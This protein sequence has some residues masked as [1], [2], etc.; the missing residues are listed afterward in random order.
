VRLEGEERE[1]DRYGLRVEYRGLS[2]SPSDCV[3]AADGSL[4]PA[5]GVFEGVLPGDLEVE[6]RAPGFPSQRALVEGLEAGETRRVELTI[7]PPVTV[8]GRVVRP[9][10]S[11]AAG[12]TVQLTRGALPGH[13][14]SFGLTTTYDVR[15]R[16]AEAVTDA[17]GRFAI[18]GLAR[19]R[20]AVRAIAGPWLRVDQRVERSALDE[21]LTIQLPQHGALEVEVL[22]DPGADLSPYALRALPA[23]SIAHALDR[24]YAEEL[25]LPVEGVLLLD[26]VRVGRVELTLA[27][28]N[29]DGVGYRDVGSVAVR[30]G[31]TTRFV[32]DLRG[33]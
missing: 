13:D 17:E 2:V 10:G 15:Y 28:E 32:V 16:D 24:W 14:V 20:Y 27:E 26:P 12:V 1:L 30:A 31:E 29:E 8:R 21:G 7:A 18:P 3:F 33:G 25:P 4:A 5:G 11:P 23:E 22:T 9:D 6:V 19:D